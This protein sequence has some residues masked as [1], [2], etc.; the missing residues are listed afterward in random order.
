MKRRAYAYQCLDA[1][2]ES[3]LAG[4][5][6]TALVSVLKSNLSPRGGRLDN[7]DDKYLL[8]VHNGEP[9]HG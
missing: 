2:R 3:A 8:K 7:M 5:T 9:V 6:L 4:Q 1:A